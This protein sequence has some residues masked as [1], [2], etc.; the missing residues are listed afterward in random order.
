V[1]IV[2]AWGR[3]T[4]PVAEGIWKKPGLTNAIC[5]KDLATK[6]PQKR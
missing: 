3:S 2:E 6:S 4:K 5:S 1:V